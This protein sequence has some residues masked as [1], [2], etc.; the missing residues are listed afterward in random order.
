MIVEGSHPSFDTPWRFALVP[1]ESAALRATA[2][3]LAEQVEIDGS[4]V[5]CMRT[6]HVEVAADFFFAS[7]YNCD[8]DA[9]LVHL[10][11]PVTGRQILVWWLEAERM[12]V[13]APEHWAA[14]LCMF[15]AAM[16][17]LHPQ[18]SYLR[19]LFPTAQPALLR[20]ALSAA[21][22]T[23]TARASVGFDYATGRSHFEVEG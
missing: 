17:T 3:T 11:A 4:A 2:P 9:P 13:N 15:R 8:P 22:A 23:P 10:D 21:F 7:H 12:I 18:G 19:L 20:S 6:F 5:S 16:A 14:V 1:Q